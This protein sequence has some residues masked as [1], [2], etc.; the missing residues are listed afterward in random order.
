MDAFIGEK[1]DFSCA[2]AGMGGFFEKKKR[3]NE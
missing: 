2:M 1:K 3:M